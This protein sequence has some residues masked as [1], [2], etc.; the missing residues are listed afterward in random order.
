M[1]L[2]RRS[3]GVAALKLA[4]GLVSVAVWVDPLPEPDEE[5]VK[6]TTTAVPSGDFAEQREDAFDGFDTPVGMVILGRN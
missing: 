4:N 5:A 1:H 6:T 3:L 2:L